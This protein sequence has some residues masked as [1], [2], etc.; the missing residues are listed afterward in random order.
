MR[1]ARIARSLSTL[2]AAGVLAALTTSPVLAATASGWS[3]GSYTASGQTLSNASADALPSGVATFDFTSAPNTALLDTTNGAFKGTLLGDDRNKTITATFHITGATGAFTY[4]GEGTSS[5]PCGTP[6]NVRLFFQ[7]SNAGGFDYTH[8]WWSDSAFALL[9]DGSFTLTANVSPLAWS[10]WNGQ[11]AEANA[12]AF[13][14]AASNVT[15]IGFSFG[16]GCFFENG[17]GT[18]DGSG[19]FDLDSFNVS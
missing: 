4:F 16:G 13:N 5:N 3:V 10:D 19:T 14:A 7:T 15:L 11:Q 6:A 8:Y 17:V 12:D 18:T 9:D 2:V 1:R